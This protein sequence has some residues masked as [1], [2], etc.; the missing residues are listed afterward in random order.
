MENKEMITYLRTNIFESNA[1][2]LVNTV[3]TVGVMGKGLAKEFKRLY[4]NMFDSYQKYCESGHLSTGKLQLFR[5]TNKWVLN[6]PT[7]QN[8][9]DSSKLE[10]IESGL[11]KF[12]DS[13][14]KQGVKS[15]SFPML[16]CGNGGLDWELQVKPLMEKYLKKLPI[17]IFIHIG[18][19][20]ELKPEHSN[21]KEIDTWLKS[22][23]QYLSSI[24]FYRHLKHRYSGLINN[25]NEQNI[26]FSVHQ[27]VVDEEEA[28]C[29]EQDSKKICLTEST[30]HHIW[31]T[32]KTNGVLQSKVLSLE[33]AQ[34][35]DMVMVFLSQLEYI[36]L[37]Q[38]GDIETQMAVRLLSHKQPISSMEESLLFVA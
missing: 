34:Y 20:D 33:L 16:G 37:T 5:T 24:E 17:E 26:K 23:A 25:V 19:V 1:H 28:F 22:E 6:F 18:K 38:L 21:Q 15:I 9:R 13:Y 32:L 29:L 12:V 4:P 8:W 30:I 10:Y 31:R 14:E 11:Q 2:V 35:A 27:V 7:K 3:N 36:S